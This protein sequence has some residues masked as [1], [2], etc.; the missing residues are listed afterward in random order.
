MGSVAFSDLGAQEL[1]K[2]F[3]ARC[4]FLHGLEDNGR[5]YPRQTI[6]EYITRNNAIALGVHRYYTEFTSFL[7]YLMKKI[8][9]C[10]RAIESGSMCEHCKERMKNVKPLKAVRDYSYPNVEVYEMKMA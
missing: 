9:P 3:L 2:V 6:L 10:T 5:R 1:Q 4:E 8:C 7:I